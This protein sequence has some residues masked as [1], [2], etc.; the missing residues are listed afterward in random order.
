MAVKLAAKKKMDSD[1][2]LWDGQHAVT[3]N[4]I[5]VRLDTSV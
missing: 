3:I 2:V 4:C 5:V 1:V